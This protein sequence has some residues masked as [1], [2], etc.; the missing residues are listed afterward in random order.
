MER[1]CGKMGGVVVQSLTGEGNLLY[2]GPFGQLS[3]PHRTTISGQR[4]VI[5]SER[6]FWLTFKIFVV[7]SEDRGYMVPDRVPARISDTSSV[8]RLRVESRGRFVLN[9]K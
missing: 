7:D 1:G 8:L 2:L 9:S 5:V 6:L 3:D 4:H